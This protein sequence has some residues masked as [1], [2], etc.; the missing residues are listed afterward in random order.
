MVCLFQFFELRENIQYF[1]IKTN[2]TVLFCNKATKFK[3]N[4]YIISS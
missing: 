2:Y 3:N 4:N 1:H